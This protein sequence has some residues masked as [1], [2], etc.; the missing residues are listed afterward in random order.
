VTKINLVT[1]AKVPGLDEARF[2]EIAAHAKATCQI[3]RLLKAAEITLNAK[4]A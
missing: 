3:S 1:N 2:D 4:L